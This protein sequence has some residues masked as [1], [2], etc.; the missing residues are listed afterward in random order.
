L[1]AVLAH[2]GQL[3]IV[4]QKHRFSQFENDAYAV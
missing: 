1:K 2:Q 4:K 3:H